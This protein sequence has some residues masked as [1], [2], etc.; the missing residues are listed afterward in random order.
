M[1]WTLGDFESN[2]IDKENY[3]SKRYCLMCNKL[4]HHT[5]KLYCSTKCNYSDTSLRRRK[6]IR[7]SK[8]ELQ[9]DIETMSFVAIGKKYGVSDNAVRKWAKKYDLI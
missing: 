3:Y 4:L 9:K 8:E 7:P 6:V 5:Q 1:H 2:I